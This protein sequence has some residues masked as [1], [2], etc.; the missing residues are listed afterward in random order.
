MTSVQLSLF[1]LR[2]PFQP[3]TLFLADGRKFVIP[4]PDFATVAQAG[5]GVWI[6]DESGEIEILDAA[7]ICS[8]RTI[9]AADI[10]QFARE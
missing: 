9:G 6:F 2:Q 3:I 7:L 1:F 5:M 4:Q 8:I 10:D